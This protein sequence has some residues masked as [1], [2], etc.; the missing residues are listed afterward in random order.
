MDDSFGVAL[1]FELVSQFLKLGA[2][3]TKIVDL[4]IEDH[5]DRTVFVA[6]RLPA[7]GDVDDGETRYGKPDTVFK[8]ITFAIRPAMADRGIQLPQKFA[9]HTL[10][11]IENELTTD[12]RT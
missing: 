10:R 2:Q 7:A 6:D 1:S 4:A 5:D 9:V 11:R 12:A 3:F 8:V